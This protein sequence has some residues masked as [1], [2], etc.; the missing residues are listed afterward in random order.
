MPLEAVD[1]LEQDLLNNLLDGL[2]GPV[3]ETLHLLLL[4]DDLRLEVLANCRDVALVL[5]RLLR[6]V[7][8]PHV[9]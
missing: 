5:T 3:V 4:E 1:F 8:V 9:L 7:S 2:L 6:L